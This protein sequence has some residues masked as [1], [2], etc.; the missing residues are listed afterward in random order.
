[1]SR[2]AEAESRRKKHGADDSANIWNLIELYPDDI[3]GYAQYAQLRVPVRYPPEAVLH[4][5]KCALFELPG[6]LNW[7][8]LE[9]QNRPHMR[10][11]LETVDYLRLQVI[12]YIQRFDH[13]T[14]DQ[15]SF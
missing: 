11:Y 4:L 9:G 14:V 2:K 1:M 12:D 6:V 10:H 3:R 7:L 8:V 5:K 13:L 15:K